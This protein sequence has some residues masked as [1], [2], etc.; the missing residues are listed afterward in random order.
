MDVILSKLESKNKRE[1]ALTSAEINKFK[2]KMEILTN[3]YEFWTE[4]F[5]EGRLIW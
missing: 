1:F 2:T 4:Y 5:L 3:M